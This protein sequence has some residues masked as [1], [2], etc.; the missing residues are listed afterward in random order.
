MTTCSTCGEKASPLCTKFDCPRI[1]L[2]DAGA[3][4]AIPTPGPTPAERAL[5]EESGD[6]SF[7]GS[8]LDL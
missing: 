7:L 3:M 2:L 4:V 1:N 6:D 8:L 5:T